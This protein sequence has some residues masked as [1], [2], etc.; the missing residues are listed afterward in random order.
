MFFHQVPFGTSFRSSFAVAPL[1]AAV[2]TSHRHV[3]YWAAAVYLLGRE[4]GLQPFDV[5]PQ[6]EHLDDRCLAVGA[7][8]DSP[9]IESDC[10]LVERLAGRHGRQAVGFPLVHDFEQVRHDVYESP[11]AVVVL[12]SISCFLHV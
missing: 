11:L 6:I 1:R 4:L 9:F 8:R 10:G 2:M 7:V 3:R 12:R 5:G